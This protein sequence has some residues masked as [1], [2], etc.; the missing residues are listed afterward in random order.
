MLKTTVRYTW[1]TLGWISLIVGLV[2]LFIPLLPTTPFI[3]LT[4][5]CFSRGSER[6]H[7]WILTHPYLGSIIRNWHDNRSIPLSAK[8][9][10]SVMMLGSIAV[11]QWH[12]RIPVPVKWG[13]SAFLIAVIVFVLTRV[14]AAKS[15]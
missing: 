8:V 4:G 3:L 10:S 12:P 1:L 7:R 11:I 6:M 5:F 13:V 9:G 2:G 15:R 14:T